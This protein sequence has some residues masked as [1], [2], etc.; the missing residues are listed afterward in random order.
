E[1][2]PTVWSMWVSCSTK[3]VISVDGNQSCLWY[4]HHEHNRLPSTI[5]G[6]FPEIDV[7]SLSV[8]CQQIPCLLEED[9]CPGFL[10]ER[11]R[12]RQAGKG[13][14][15]ALF[16]TG[17]LGEGE[18]HL[19]TE[20]IRPVFTVELGRIAQQGFRP[21]GGKGQ[22]G[23]QK[24]QVLQHHGR[25]RRW[26]DHHLQ[27]D[28]SLDQLVQLVDACICICKARARSFLDQ[29]HALSHPS[30]HDPAQSQETSPPVHEK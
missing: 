16:G 14:V 8:C 27:V 6:S 25:W 9:L 15:L 28:L 2:A 24:A 18:K 22:V 7:F 4:A 21:A 1:R 19:G 10:E 26:P 3:S 30:P 23:K 5:V 17:E 29:L 12:F 11:L 13:L 20:T